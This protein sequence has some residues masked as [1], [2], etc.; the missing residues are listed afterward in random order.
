MPIRNNPILSHTICSACGE[1]AMKWTFFSPSKPVRYTAVNS[2]SYVRELVRWVSTIG[3]E[4]PVKL[5]NIVDSF[6]NDQHL[7]K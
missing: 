3:H 7:L 5:P 2:H 4:R 1:V 6:P